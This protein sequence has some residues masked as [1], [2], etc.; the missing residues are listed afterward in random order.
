[1]KKVISFIL[2]FIVLIRSCLIIFL[3]FNNYSNNKN[4]K[5]NQKTELPK[6][7]NNANEIN[8]IEE[9]NTKEINK[10]KI[11]SNSQNEK[12]ETKIE[13]KKNINEDN[14]KEIITNNENK[15]TEVP[16]KNNKPEEEKQNPIVNDDSL[17]I[18]QIDEE[19]ERLKNLIKY[20]TSKECYD[21][22]VEIGLKYLDNDNFQNTACSSFSY[23]GQLL[24]YR[25]LI[26]YK[27]G[28]T[29]YL[30]TIG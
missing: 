29:E 22:S 28:T 3:N 5:Q 24:G 23:K 6:L 16:S 11:N 18:P 8:K 10:E 20:K 14:K 13:Q 7:N 19:L 21:A 15:I 17:V 12:E 9:E 4:P 2:V 25:L 1:M 30:D 26:Y 27:D